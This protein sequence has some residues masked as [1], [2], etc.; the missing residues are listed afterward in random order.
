LNELGPSNA[1]D[2]AVDP[3][4]PSLFQRG[5]KAGANVV[6]YHR[7]EPVLMKLDNSLFK[8]IMAGAFEKCGYVPHPAVSG[9]I[10]AL[11]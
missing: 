9:L 10:V 2:E 5:L 1:L 11:Y 6:Q 3:R 8:Q 7:N 4:S